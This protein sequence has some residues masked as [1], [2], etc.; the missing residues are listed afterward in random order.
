[1]NTCPLLNKECIGNDCK[2]WTS[3]ETIDP[4][5]ILFRIAGELR[6]VKV[7]LILMDDALGRLQTSGE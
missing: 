2:W 7:R 5:C 3:T 6:Q 4:D 1:M